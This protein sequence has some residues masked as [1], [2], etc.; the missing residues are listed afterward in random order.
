MYLCQTI[1]CMNQM[2]N[3]LLHS[4]PSSVSIKSIYPRSW[5]SE[6]NLQLF[7]NVRHTNSFNIHNVFVVL[8]FNTFISKTKLSSTEAQT[9]I[10]H[11]FLGMLA[12]RSD[13]LENREQSFFSEVS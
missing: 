1:N 11:M 6:S 8:D 9:P 4:S 13:N 2:H 7:L 5:L 12:N 3:V 10:H